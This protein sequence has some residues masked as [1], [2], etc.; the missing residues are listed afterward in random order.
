[1]LSVS[2][3]HPDVEDFIDAKMEQGKVTGANISVRITDEFMQ[4]VDSANN[5][6]HKYPVDNANPMVIREASA[7]SLW[8][9]IVHNA[10][11][12]AEPGIL[13]WDSITRESIADCYAHLG[14]KTV[15]TNPCGDL[16]AS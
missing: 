9:K 1:M 7:E 14:F 8:K 11:R 12:S 16:F 10:W 5:F 2:V 6:T 15:S 4:A 13:F 3:E